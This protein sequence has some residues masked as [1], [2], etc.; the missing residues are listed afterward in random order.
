MARSRSASCS[1]PTSFTAVHTFPFV[2]DLSHAP[3]LQR[4]GLDVNFDVLPPVLRGCTDVMPAIP[5]PVSPLTREFVCSA[6]RVRC[7][8]S[9]LQ[10]L[11]VLGALL[12]EYVGVL[13]PSSNLTGSAI[14]VQLHA[15]T[16]DCL[17]VLLVIAGIHSKL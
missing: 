12:S 13:P 15:H 8:R 2:A 14:Y 9:S 17:I 5:P 4:L 3:H 11:T 6:D 10:L 7:A 1:R 16:R